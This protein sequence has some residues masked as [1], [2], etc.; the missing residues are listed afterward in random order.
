MPGTIRK[1]P[2]KLNMTKQPTIVEKNMAIEANI[3]KNPTKVPIR[4]NVE[5]AR[6]LLKN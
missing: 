2:S 1:S 3:K 4:S 6:D 5:T